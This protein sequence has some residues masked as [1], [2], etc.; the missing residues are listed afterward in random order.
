MLLLVVLESLGQ[1][2]LWK[3]VEM[4]WASQGLES[5]CVSLHESSPGLG[6]QQYLIRSGPKQNPWLQC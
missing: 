2:A 5:V 6:E 4:V 1:L 3:W